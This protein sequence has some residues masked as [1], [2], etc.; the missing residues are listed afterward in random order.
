M[1]PNIDAGLTSSVNDEM[2]QPSG[3]GVPGIMTPFVTTPG[4]TVD[5]IGPSKG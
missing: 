1:F 3:K 5:M 2:Q 4:M